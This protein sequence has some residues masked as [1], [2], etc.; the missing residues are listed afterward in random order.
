MSGRLLVKR[1]H[2]L[3]VKKE[4]ILTKMADSPS[5]TTP[6]LPLPNPPLL[7]L[8]LFTVPAPLSVLSESPSLAELQGRKTLL[9]HHIQCALDVVKSIDSNEKTLQEWI[10]LNQKQQETTQSE[11][12]AE[13]EKKRKRD[14]QDL[15]LGVGKKTAL[16]DPADK[17]KPSK[18]PN[19]P[20]SIPKEA[21][22]ELTDN[23]IPVNEIIK[24]IRI[25]HKS[26]RSSSIFKNMTHLYL[27]Q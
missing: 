11:A 20:A 17:S 5:P 21:M 2:F 16:A 12:T 15:G 9:E 14:P 13:L 1:R 27:V 7:N 18:S 23:A 3:S 25:H 8:E 6:T 10:S 4:K 19:K 22:P 24:I 26:Y